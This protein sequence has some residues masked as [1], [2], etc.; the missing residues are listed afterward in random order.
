MTADS[1]DAKSRPF[2]DTGSSMAS[3]DC[4]QVTPQVFPFLSN[5][6]ASRGSSRAPFSLQDS[7]QRST[8][9]LAHRCRPFD[10]RG[11]RWDWADQR[12]VPGGFG[13]C[14][15][16]SSAEALRSAAARGIIAELCSGAINRARARLGGVVCAWCATVS[17][18][19]RPGSAPGFRATCASRMEARLPVWPIPPRSEAQP[20]EEGGRISRPPSGARGRCRPGAQPV[21]VSIGSA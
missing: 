5:G 15:R 7:V 20:H 19:R 17:A 9:N 11:G 12:Q 14:V 16:Q 4:E 8:R 1:L 3:S 2:F 21:F 10:V 13:H 18:H 6:E